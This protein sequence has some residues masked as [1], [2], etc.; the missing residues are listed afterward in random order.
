M[1]RTALLPTT[2]GL[3]VA[4]VAATTTVHGEGFWENGQFRWMVSTPLLAVDLSKLPPSPEHPWLAIKDPSIVRYEGQWHLFCTLRKNKTGDGR[5]RI[6][7]LRFN[8]WSE[9]AQANWSVL[10][11]T[12]DYHGAP[13]IFYFTP[14]QTWYLIYQAS[15]EKRGLAYGPCYSTN[16]RIDDPAGWTKPQPLY[17]VPEGKKAGLDFW[18]ICDESKAYLFFTSLDGRMWRAETSLDQFPATGWSEPVVALEA[19]IFEASHTYRL[20]G[21]EQ[22]VTLV[23]AQAPGRRYFK[24]FAAD[25]LDGQWRPL[26]DTPAKP[27]VSPLNVVNQDESWA[28]SYSHGEFLRAGYDQRLEIDPASPK[29]LFQGASDAEYRGAPYGNIP[30]RLGLLEQVP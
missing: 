2:L 13:Q 30:W 26:A 20:A 29:I 9:A 10:D 24:A 4:L 12:D 7:Y 18:V 25:R 21:R 6:G 28:D 11:L 17:V 22:F 14:H 27:F 5:I 23:E 16:P 3:I 8:D 1:N 19:D 15:D